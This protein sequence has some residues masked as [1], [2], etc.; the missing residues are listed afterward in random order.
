MPQILLKQTDCAVCGTLKASDCLLGTFQLR[1]RIK[2]RCDND[3]APP[4][5]ARILGVGAGT[6]SAQ[7]F[8]ACCTWPRSTKRGSLAGPGPVDALSEAIGGGFCR[9]R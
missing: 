8:C 7:R 1:R 5:P 2:W 4:P 6:L 3:V 9:I